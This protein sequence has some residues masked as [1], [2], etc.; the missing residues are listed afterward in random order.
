[1]LGIQLTEKPFFAF[2]TFDGLVLE[3]FAD[4][5]ETGRRYHARLI[6]SIEL[7]TD[8]KGRHHLKMNT[9]LVSLDQEVDDAVV[10]EVMELVAQ[11]QKAMQ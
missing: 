1:M 7:A 8:K 5:L 6:K 11:V 10:G 3:Y 2:V 4:H 9:R